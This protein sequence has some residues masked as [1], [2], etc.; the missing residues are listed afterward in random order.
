MSGVF[1]AMSDSI[2]IPEAPVQSGVEV[3]DLDRFRGGA[4]KGEAAREPHRPA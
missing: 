2:D 1:I 3:W 4:S